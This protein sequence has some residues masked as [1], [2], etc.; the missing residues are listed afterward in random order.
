MSVRISIQRADEATEAMKHICKYGA[1]GL[2]LN[3][4]DS[5]TKQNISISLDGGNVFVVVVNVDVGV[6]IDVDDVVVF[7]DIAAA[8][9]VVR[10][11]GEN[12]TKNFKIAVSL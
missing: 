7:I 10:L 9:V 6:D 12:M 5:L 1:E 4:D 8:V 3:G 11:I 2:I